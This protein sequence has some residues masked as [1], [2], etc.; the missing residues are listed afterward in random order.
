MGDENEHT[1]GLAP[2]FDDAGKDRTYTDT[3][4]HDLLSFMETMDN[5]TTA[6]ERAIASI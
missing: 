1:G 5:A 3:E 2:L 6:D 4:L